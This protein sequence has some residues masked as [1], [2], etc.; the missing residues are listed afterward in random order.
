[1]GDV[2]DVRRVPDFLELRAPKGLCRHALS[3]RNARRHIP[4]VSKS[5][6][7]AD[8]LLVRETVLLI[9]ARKLLQFRRAQNEDAVTLPRLQTQPL[10]ER[11][12]HPFGRNLSVKLRSVPQK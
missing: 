4:Q 3:S 2:G 7:R 9:K 6:S 8:L 11:R 10:P 12:A 1:M 5:T